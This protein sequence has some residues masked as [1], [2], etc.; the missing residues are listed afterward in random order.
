MK[1]NIRDTAIKVFGNWDRESVKETMGYSG[2]VCL[3]TGTLGFAI[4]GLTAGFMGAA[5]GVVAPP[6]AVAFDHARKHY[7]AIAT[8]PTLAV[9]GLVISGGTL[10]GLAI[11]TIAGGLMPATVKKLRQIGSWLYERSI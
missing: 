4:G 3:S 11:G 7:G 9:A 5:I 8:A 10:E 2:V 6:T 1:V